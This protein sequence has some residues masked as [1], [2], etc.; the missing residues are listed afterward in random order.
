[1]ASI[2]I[3]GPRRSHIPVAVRDLVRSGW[4]P[5]TAPVGGNLIRNGQLVVLAMPGAEAKLRL[6]IYKVTGS[7]RHRESERRI[8]ITTTYPKGL[9]KE[10]RYE[11]VVLGYD[12]DTGCYVGVDARRL[13]FG[14]TTGN[15]S[16]FFD[17]RGLSAA[18]NTRIL[19]LP[20]QTTIIPGGV[21]YH[22]FF[23]AARLSEYLLNMSAIHGG[24]YDGKGRDSGSTRRRGRGSA[25][26]VARRAEGEVL[27]LSKSS[28]PARAR[29]ANAAL[30]RELERGYWGRSVRA[31]VSP[32]ELEATLRRSAENGA[33]GEQVVVEAERAR[34]VR[35]GRHDLSKRVRHVSLESVMEGYDVVSY[36]LNGTRRFIEV[37]ATEGSSRSFPMSMGEWRVAE[38]KRSAYWIY[39][40]FDVRKVPRI[41]RYQDPVGLEVQ[42]LLV[43]QSDGWTIRVG[44]T[45]RS[46]R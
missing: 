40:V 45:R 29:L 38:A 39:R 6:F 3:V 34:L 30:T 16:S 22:A 19:I 17:G 31:T 32:E 18:T 8:E 43:R 9:A 5:D 24:A 23:R 35:A 44:G 4:I 7:G 20:R 28:I 1:M 26:I 14:G 42:H 36:D 27:R 2:E 46:A 12:P 13:E 25:T 11:D 37:K 21:E 33:L 10:R 41:E 15:A